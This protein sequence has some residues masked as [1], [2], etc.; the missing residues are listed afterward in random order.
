M[1]FSLNTQL[2]MK[3]LFPAFMT[4]V[5]TVPGLIALVLLSHALT[6]NAQQADPKPDYSSE[7]PRIPATEPSETLKNFEV[8]DGYEI[9]LVASEPLVSTPVAIEWD[10]RGGLYVCEMRGYS[11]NRDDGISRVR[12]L[13]DSDQDGVYDQ[14]TTF[15]SQLLWPTA[16]F[17]YKGGLFIADAPNIYYCK[18]TNGDGVAD[19]KSIVLTGFGTSNVQGLVNSFRWGLD[20][21]I[22]VACSSVGGN[23]QRPNDQQKPLN[24]RGRDLSFDPDTYEIQLTSGG[25]QHGMCFDDWGRKYVSSNSDH[26]QQ[27]IY[28]DRYVARNPLFSASSAR[29][30]I[31]ADGPQAPVFRSSPVEPWRIVRTRLRVGGVVPGPV[32]GGGRASGYFTGATGVTIYRGDNWPQKHHGIAIVGDV[33]SNLIH[34]KLLTPDGVQMIATRMD[35]ASEFVRSSDIW[36]R[37]A[38]FANAPDGSLHVVDVCREVIEHPKSLAPSIKQ[39]LDLNAGRD[40]GR[41]YRVIAKNSQPRLN[42][43]FTK[44]KP[45]E[46]ASSLNHPN[47]WHRETASRLI[48][49]LQPVSIKSSLQEMVTTASRPQGRLHALYALDSLDALAA[50][51]VHEAMK[52]SHPQVRKHALCLAETINFNAKMLQT[53]ASMVEDENAE[54]R[55]QLAFS[56]SEYRHPSTTQILTRLITQDVDSRWMRLAVQSSLAV[57]AGDLFSQLTLD[58]TFRNHSAAQFLV[59][60]AKQ[61]VRQNRPDELQTAMQSFQALST[62]APLFSLPILGPFQTASSNPTASKQLQDL[63]NQLTLAAIHFANNPDNAV[64]KRCSTIESLSYSNWET[65]GATL[66]ELAVNQDSPLVSQTAITVASKFNS[67]QLAN[68]LLKQ[69]DSKT[70]GWRNTAIEAIF[71]RGDRIKILFQAI[72]DGKI[73]L[74]E[75]PR[76]RLTFAANSRDKQVKQQ[77]LTFLKATAAPNRRD[78]LERY[79]AALSKNQDLADGRVVFRKHCSG[80]HRLENVGYEIGPNLA[81]MKA[82]GADA[83][84]AN[85]LDPNLEVNPQYINYVLLKMDGST[86]TGMIAAENANSITLKREESA[87]ETILRGDVE[88]MR[89]SRKSIMPEGFEQSITPQ[90]MANLVTY[91]MQVN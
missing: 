63:I 89:S 42:P 76:S 48:H 26:I 70:P 19:L 7:L 73:Q 50:E 28:Q 75:V 74:N 16:I 23:I 66:M 86:A 51:V 88:Q 45:E 18:D 77:A 60:L 21:R 64:E 84:L 49:E 82:R 72:E 11:E 81:T 15:A 20:N 87:T 8:A 1:H 24:V 35:S 13:T 69:W 54:V 9:Q 56:V 80:C 10:A 53:V 78:V 91:L 90:Q 71:S 38:Q 22:H 33:G 44:L 83:M 67:G 14:A 6:L 2:T 30:S 58:E 59:S 41:I 79:T 25:A 57:G 17:P 55:L 40:R 29:V 62:S 65:V 47:A 12:Y 32:E 37:P 39:H 68:F 43:D 61:I 36:F 5:F 46:L 3:N 31:A 34:R 52:D 27:V 4:P 85:I